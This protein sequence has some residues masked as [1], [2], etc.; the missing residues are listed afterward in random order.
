[1]VIYRFLPDWSGYI[2]GESVRL[3][4]T[5][6]LG[7]NYGDPCISQ[8][9][10]DSYRQANLVINNNV[11]QKGYHPDHVKLLKRLQVKSNL[12]IPI[13]Q[14][15]ELFGLL[16]A[17]HCQSLHTWEADEINY[18]QQIGVSL[19]QS[20]AGLGLLERKQAEAERIQ[21]QNK[22][23][24]MELLQLLSDVEGAASGNLT[25]RADIGEGQI[26]IV[27]DFFNAIIE[28]LRDIVTQVKQTT[29]QVNASLDKD[30]VEVTQLAQESQKQAKKIQQMLSFIEDMVTSIEK[31]ANN[32]LTAAQ[33]AQNASK[34]ASDSATAMDQTVDSIGNLRE[35]VA[36]TAK[37][38][39]RLGEASQQ[40]SKVISLINEIAL[41]TNLLAVNASI[42]AARAGEEGRGFAVVAEEVGQLAAQSTTATKE[43]EQIVSAIQKETF[44]VV[45]A[46][47][48]G[49]L[50]VVEGTRLLEQAKRSLGEIVA[51]SQE[52]DQLVQSISESTISQ[53]KTSEMVSDFMKDIAKVSDAYS[54]A[55]R[56]VSESL[57]NTVEIAINLQKS[58]DTF[59]VE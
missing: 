43:I 50:Q 54:D 34:Q 2:A 22:Q 5:P 58:V 59:K 14:G 29:A 27:A 57:K 42:E 19:A 3:G 9:I 20:L 45:E 52:I 37:K 11:D 15:G 21:T 17:H 8:E 1:V 26:G 30:E 25:V 10:L 51:D 47:E 13:V 18:L 39:K 44:E 32:A 35:T 41:K 55:S 7:D 48:T 12:I 6:A 36:M 40:I 46:M 56:Q 38:V 16:I 31:V 49:T 24:Q 28:N 23:L 53:A 33:T 4:F